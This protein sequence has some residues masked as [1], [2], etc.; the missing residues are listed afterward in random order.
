SGLTR[1][2]ISLYAK[3]A[4]AEGFPPPVARVMSESPLWDW[5]KVARWMHSHESRVS[6]HDVLQARIV[7]QMNLFFVQRT[8]PHSRL[9]KR[10]SGAKP[11]L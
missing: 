11:N 5:Y 6:L 10:F 7:R 1:A 2:A 3:G 9:A 8:V 4:R